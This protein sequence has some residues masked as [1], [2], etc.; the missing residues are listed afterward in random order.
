MSTQ[1]SFCL[2]YLLNAK[3]DRLMFVSTCVTK[4]KAPEASFKPFFSLFCLF[5]YSGV[6][7]CHNGHRTV[8]RVVSFGVIL[9]LLIIM[10]V[11]RNVSDSSSSDEEVIQVGR[12]WKNRICSSSSS[13]NDELSITHI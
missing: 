4:W 6:S 3:K 7:H 10:S 12:K 9:T 13:E 11:W 8:Q 5:F 2:C 1:V